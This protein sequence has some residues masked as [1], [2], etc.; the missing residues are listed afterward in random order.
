MTNI[1]SFFKEVLSFKDEEEKLEFKG[2]MLQL[3]IVNKFLRRM[4]AKGLS[5]NQLAKKAGISKRYLSKIFAGDARIRMTTMVQLQEALDIK[6]NINFIEKK[7]EKKIGD[8]IDDELRLAVLNRDYD[9]VNS[10]IKQV[11]NIHEQDCFGFTPL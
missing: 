5:Q 2:N 1:D 7:V 4:E 8:N 11:T 3:D 9:K 10:L 6:I